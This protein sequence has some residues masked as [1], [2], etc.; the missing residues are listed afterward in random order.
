[1]EFCDANK[2]KKTASK[3]IVMNNG[4]KQGTRLRIEAELRLAYCK[5]KAILCRV[6]L[7]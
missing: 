7:G 3:G 4:T 5:V 1:M 6:W 2:R